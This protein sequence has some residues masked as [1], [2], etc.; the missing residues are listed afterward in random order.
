[1]L[2]P[3]TNSNY[4]INTETKNHM[5]KSIFVLTNVLLHWFTPKKK[6]PTLPY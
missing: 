6:K 3:T 5:L 2:P 1:M 4:Y